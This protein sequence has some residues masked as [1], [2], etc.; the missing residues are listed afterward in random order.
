MR[1][2]RD[3]QVS[4]LSKIEKTLQTKNEVVVAS[5]PN[6]GKTFIATEF[7]RINPTS[8]FLV[9]THGTLV[10]KKQ[11]QDALN[12][13]NLDFSDKLGESRISYGVPQGLYRKQGQN[14]DYLIIDEAHEFT[15]AEMIKEIKNK[16]K[17]KK[18]I[19]LTGTPSKFIA[20]K[21]EVIIVPALDLIKQGFSSDL[22]IGMVSTNIALRDSDRNSDGDIKESSNKKLEKTVKEDL[23]ELLQSI[24]KRL[25]ETGALKGSP[26]IRKTAEWVPTLGKL[27]KTMVACQSIKQATL[28]QKYFIK[29][30]IN[31][32]MSHSELDLDSENIQDF[33]ENPDVKV[34]VV[35]NRGILGFNMENLVNVVDLTLSRN[36][37]RIYQLYA[38]VM[39]TSEEHS[40][41]YFFKFA[42]EQNMLLDK[43]YM[44]AAIAMLSEDFI[45]KFNGKNLKNI[46]VPVAVRPIDKNNSS[47]SIP[48]SRF[49]VI[50]K[51]FYETISVGSALIDIHNKIGQSTNEYAYTT[52]GKI[53][54]SN[55]DIKIR[56]DHAYEKCL[57]DARK[58]KSRSQWALNSKN[59]YRAAS[60]Y[61]WIDRVANDIGW[62]F[63]NISHTYDGCLDDARKYGSRI[64]WKSKN[65]KYYAS[66]ITNGWLQD[67]ANELGWVSMNEKANNR[68]KQLLHLANT[69]MERPKKGTDLLVRLNRCIK[70]DDSFVDQ[71]KKTKYG[72]IWLK[73]KVGI[74]YVKFF[75]N[76]EKAKI[77]GVKIKIPDIDKYNG[78]KV[79]YVFEC[80]KYGKFK[81]TPASIV[82]SWSKGLSGHPEMG[83]LAGLKSRS[84][85]R[86]IIRSDGK[87]F[88]NFTDASKAIGVDRKYISSAVKDKIK[89]KGYTFDYV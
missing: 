47:K 52:F 10:L 20:K 29:N 31:S 77:N 8:T 63:L 69:Q 25:K 81:T 60:K 67:I 6:S 24:H 51:D 66:A 74:S 86:S 76:W 54:E 82:R 22:Y 72:S 11:W 38:R 48:K 18:I 62:S 40:K 27:H 5:A 56:I 19:Y 39:R 44:N 50:E 85:G 65:E 13:A 41:K 88:K 17:P 59:Y 75:R 23:D 26:A 84:H 45:S 2:L 78:T 53:L 61:G 55:F 34:L 35:V 7:M 71:L 28:V 64:E 43:F 37:D 9:L 58:Y 21:Y 12:E 68:K 4:V 49:E 57:D 3:Y 1:V 30:G 14:F 36:I 73:G 80:D 33:K 70:N 83:R 46:G 42:T 16:F 32:I 87:L 15:F 89:I 79:K